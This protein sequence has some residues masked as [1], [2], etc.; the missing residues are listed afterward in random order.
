MTDLHEWYSQQLQ[1]ILQKSNENKKNFLIETQN[2]MDV[3]QIAKNTEG[4]SAQENLNKMKANFDERRS[5]L[6][7]KV[8]SYE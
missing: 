1:N 4:D 3:I 7:T 8:R 6:Q 2:D 5:E